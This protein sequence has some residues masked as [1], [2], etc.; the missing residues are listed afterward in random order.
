MQPA[1]LVHRHGGIIPTSWEFGSA[2]SMPMG[3]RR[4]VSPPTEG[5]EG[6]DRSAGC[7][8]RHWH[9]SWRGPALPSL[10]QS[11]REAEHRGSGCGGEGDGAEPADPARGSWGGDGHSIPALPSVI[12]SPLPHHGAVGA[13]PGSPCLSFPG[14]QGS[15]DLCS[16]PHHLPGPPSL[17][18]EGADSHAAPSLAPWVS[19]LPAVGGPDC[20]ATSGG[21]GCLCARVHRDVCVAMGVHT[22]VLLRVCV[23]TWMRAGVQ[24]LV[25]WHTRVSV[26]CAS[27]CCHQ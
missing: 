8:A 14:R 12:Q 4:G 27:C 13:K 25:C 26:L 23:H 16:P 17:G 24:V 2:F 11:C 22:H 1:R 19:P 5:A 10:G 21:G 3:G 9:P 20:T 18:A 15:T 7:H 6:G